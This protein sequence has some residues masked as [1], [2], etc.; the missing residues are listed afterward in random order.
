MRQTDATKDR[1]KG[2]PVS[3]K[4]FVFLAFEKDSAQSRNVMPLPRLVLL[5]LQH[6]AISLSHLHQ[7]LLCKRGFI[8]NE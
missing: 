8:R 7:L 5:K 1:H 4:T 6:L 3:L 2:L